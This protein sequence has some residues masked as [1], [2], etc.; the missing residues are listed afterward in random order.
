MAHLSTDPSSKDRWIVVYPAYLNSRRT[1][2]QGRRV[3]KN[4]ATDNPTVYE[5][6]DVCQSQGLNCELENKC[7]PR[8]S[9]KDAMSKGRVRVQLKQSDESFINE[10]F[11]SR[12]ALFRFL[13]E[14]IPKLKSRQ[15]K[16]SQ[17]DSSSGQ[18]QGAGASSK[19]KKG[20]KGKGK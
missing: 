17:S 4:K 6:R 2:E 11:Q 5:I 10:K 13:G 7:Y 1:V 16:S 8:D 20:K 12:K 9:A 14:M 19:K 3:P 18:Q 15:S